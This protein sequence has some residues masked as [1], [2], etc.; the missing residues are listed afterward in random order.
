[1]FLTLCTQHYLEA[2]IFESQSVARVDA[3]LGAEVEHCGGDREITHA[4]V[5]SETA[6]SSDYTSIL[7]T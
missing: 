3:V 1:M 4:T 7:G 2:C 6:L 5:V